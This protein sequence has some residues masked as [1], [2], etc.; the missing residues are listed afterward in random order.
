MPIPAA[1]LEGMHLAVEDPA[2]GRMR[3]DA[4]AGLAALARQ[5]HLICHAGHLV[6]RLALAAD[7]PRSLASRARET[8]HFDVSELFAFVAPALAATPTP[9]GLLRALG[10]R[11]PGD[12]LQ[13]L[14]AVAA[15]LLERLADRGYPD[16]RETAEL[17]GFLTRS[18]WP[19]AEPVLEAMRRGHG[20]IEPP[21]FATGLN[22]WD[23]VPEWQEEGPRPPGSQ[24]PVSE[25]EARR[26]LSRL[27]GPGA[28]ARPSQESYCA[29]AVT[30][31][32]PRESR[33]ENH[34]L[35]AEAGTGLGKTLGYLS[36]S[37]LWAQRNMAP[38]WLSTYT[39]NLQRQLE[40]EAHRLAPDPAERRRRVVIRKGRENYACLLNMQ[41]A[42]GRLTAANPSSALLAGLIARWARYSRDGDM[43][44]GDFPAWLLGIFE[45]GSVAGGS[46][47][48]GLGLTDRRGECIYSACPHYR[49]CFIERAARAARKADLVIA[50]HALVLHQAAIDHLIGQPVSE[51]GQDQT[52]GLRRLVFDEGHHLFDAADAAFSGHLTGQEAVEL[53]R[54]IRG[55]ET[56]GR[57]GRGL[58]DRLGELVEG[59]EQAE[60]HVQ[61]I[62][63]GARALPG[64]GWLRRVEAG[65]SEGPAEA[66]LCH[67]REQV[68]ARAKPP[69][70][71]QSIETDCRPPVGG[72]IEAAGVLARA[73]KSLTLP[74]AA[75][76]RHLTRM[77]D[78]KAAELQSAER[79]RIEA[80]ARSLKRRGELQAGAWV[81]MLD[82]LMGEPDPMRV[83]WFAIEQQGGREVDIGLHSHWIDPTVP[84]AAAVLSQAD[85]IVITSATLKD[86]PPE[87]PDDWHNAEMRTGVVHL[88]YPV[89]RVSHE[90]PF[91]YGA[92]SRVIV[93]NDINRNDIDQLAA[94]YRELFLA[95][96]GGAL[97]LFTAISRLRAVHARLLRPLAQSGLPLYA[98]H[99][100]PIDTG[101]LIDMFRAEEQAC[102][103]G[104]DAVRDGVDVPGPS[105]RLIV[106]DRVPWNQPSILDR[107]RRAAFGGNEWQDMM[108]RLKL[109]QAFGRLIRRATDRGVF[110]VL[111][112]RLASRF[113]TAFPPGLTID[114]MG[115]VDAIE[116]VKDFLDEPSPSLPAPSG[117][118]SAPDG[119]RPGQ[120]RP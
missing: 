63:A 30:A 82:E 105:L 46:S 11:P 9:H 72:L 89:K 112:S 14:R 13:A 34:I 119:G 98:Q 24:Q 23:R 90:S 56:Q 78:E 29:S 65:A 113:A 28:E 64:P 79:A 80:L 115:L 17:A 61:A 50:N 87:A 92:N 53:R 42:F 32:A 1:V 75:L 22:V 99:V 108:V 103:L 26:L 48:S 93:V 41:E 70:G 15:E 85:G 5:P 66:F 67:V 36:P 62:L 44:G 106:L 27:L 21:A 84:L 91:D 101:T 40:Q 83:A 31:F 111:D 7:A 74:M 69:H 38:V 59:D 54:W 45:L 100:D 95:A 97:G 76:A 20:A 19:W 107:A 4:K 81:G 102:L 3:V 25:D 73:L 88:P 49:R 2:Q 96:R 52:G 6:G 10:L 117:R 8:R 94:A 86:R 77:L 110:V 114:R 43:V 109:R 116:A 16:L 60:R 35:L 104:T 39:K 120:A 57:R 68:L 33:H 51:D 55:P 37:W 71:G 18:R 12:P 47:P 58:T 118:S